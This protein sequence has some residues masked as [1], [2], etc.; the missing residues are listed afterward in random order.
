MG[1]S[2]GGKASEGE[3]RREGGKEGRSE[4]GIAD[5]SAAAAWK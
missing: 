5:A 1:R 4:G 3:R 2:E